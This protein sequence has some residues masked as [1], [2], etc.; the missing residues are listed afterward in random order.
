M[1]GVMLKTAYPSSQDTSSLVILI[2]WELHRMDGTQS[3]CHG[4]LPL[5]A[6]QRRSWLLIIFKNNTFA[7]YH[8]ADVFGCAC[9]R[10]SKPSTQLRQQETHLL[11]G[12]TAG[13]KLLTRLK[14]QEFTVWDEDPISTD[15]KEQA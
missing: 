6:A 3:R 5:S 9:L 12:A 2:L 7:Q 13:K 1:L 10:P 8:A 4:R 14:Q 15:R 11:N